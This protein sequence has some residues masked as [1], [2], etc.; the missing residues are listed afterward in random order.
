MY[1]DFNMIK[2]EFTYD[3]RKI[4]TYKDAFCRRETLA[5]Y[6][7][8]VN[9]PFTRT[10]IDTYLVNN[11]DRD[12]KWWSTIDPKSELSSLINP[13]YMK[14]IDE[15]D[16]SRVAVTGQYINYGTSNTVDFIHSDVTLNQKNAFTILH[17]VNHKWDIN[18]H[19]Y[20]LWYDDL[21]EDVIHGE[22]PE[23]GKIVVFDSSIQHSSLAPS[24]VAEH[25]RF[26]IATKLFLR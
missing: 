17:Y 9:A 24:T 15:L 14:V 21:C 3:D 11:L 2:K 6:D 18:W 13:K 25:P 16:W 12:A 23:P 22:A 26:T 10:N 5:I 8:I 1:K 7:E 4:F 19:G 20:T